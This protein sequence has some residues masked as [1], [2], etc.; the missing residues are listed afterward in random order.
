LTVINIQPNDYLLYFWKL[1]HFYGKNYWTENGSCYLPEEYPWQDQAT[2]YV[3]NYHEMKFK[4][5]R[6][7]YGN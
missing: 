6:E 7:K 1:I 4:E 3:D 5:Y 2:V